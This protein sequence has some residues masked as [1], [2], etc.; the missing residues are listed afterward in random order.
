MSDLTKKIIDNFNNFNGK[1]LDILDSFYATDVYFKD[2]VTVKKNLK[3]LK[4]YYKHAYKNVT[5]IKFEF[6]EISNEGRD[7]FAPWTMHLAAK[8]LNK[9][10]SFPV[11]GMSHMKFNEAGLVDYHRDYVDLGEMIYERLPL[12]GM[13]ISKIKKMLS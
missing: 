7:Y 10:N 12:L 11:S 8:G 4:K 2:P 3:E 9:G 5:S 13:L 6:G 1:N